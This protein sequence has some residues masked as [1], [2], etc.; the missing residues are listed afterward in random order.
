METAETAVASTYLFTAER[1]LPGELWQ[2][3]VFGMGRFIRS[4]CHARAVA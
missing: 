4:Y 2:P 1:R 3:E